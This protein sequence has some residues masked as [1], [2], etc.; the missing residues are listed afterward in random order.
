MVHEPFFQ[1]GGGGKG[2]TVRPRAPSRRHLVEGPGYRSV[3]ERVAANVRRLR[4]SRG[5]TQ[6]EF[7]ERCGGLDLTVLRAI[8]NGRANLT[9][10]TVARLCE[11]LEVD[12]S[13]VFAEGARFIPARIG[14]PRKHDA[15]E[16]AVESTVVMHHAAAPERSRR[17]RSAEA[18]AE[19]VIRDLEA[20]AGVTWRFGR[21]WAQ[22]ASAMVCAWE[23]T[24]GESAAPTWAGVIV[25]RATRREHLLAE[26]REL[27]AAGIPWL[28]TIDVEARVVSVVERV[29]GRWSEVGHYPEGVTEPL[30]PFTD[31]VTVA[32]AWW[33]AGAG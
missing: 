31:A 14:R 11:G 25:T 17:T 16:L 19:R 18:F 1:V 9:A 33:D 27:A 20:R 7:A 4:Q 12:V 29:A 23:R 8:E 22:I 5:W 15:L 13:E 10:I 21:D 28:W 32:S 2:P 6:D 30:P 24:A 3:V 26:R